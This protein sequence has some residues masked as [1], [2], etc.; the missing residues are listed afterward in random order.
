MVE[1]EADVVA[2]AADATHDGHAWWHAWWHAWCHAWRHAWRH[3]WHAGNVA[4]QS[5]EI[6]PFDQSC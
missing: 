4:C 1:P 6:N 5:W 3:A 2:H